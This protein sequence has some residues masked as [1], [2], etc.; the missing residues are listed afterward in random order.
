MRSAKLPTKTKTT[1]RIFPGSIVSRAN[2]ASPASS[3]SEIHFF[4]AL[5][6]APSPAA[7]IETYGAQGRIRTSVAPKNGRFTVCCH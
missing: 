7:L 3:A 4:A 1:I 5:D 2:P 6:I